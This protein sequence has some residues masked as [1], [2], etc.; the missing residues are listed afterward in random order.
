MKGIGKFERSRKLQRKHIDLWS[1]C[2]DQ[3]RA[4][5]CGPI[6]NTHPTLSKRKEEKLIFL[7]LLA[8]HGRGSKLKPQSKHKELQK[9][10][11]WGKHAEEE[12][13]NDGGK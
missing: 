6:R 12:S 13:V 11:S 5:H 2:G 9:N 8:L 1:L 4:P 3:N 7:E 10:V